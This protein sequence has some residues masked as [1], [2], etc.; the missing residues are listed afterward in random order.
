MG[1]ILNP[2]SR[3][4]RVKYADRLASS[5]ILNIIIRFDKIATANYAL[6]NTF[7]GKGVNVFFN[8]KSD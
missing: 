8:T 6:M 1:T 5:D 3:R 7:Y 4:P 2:C